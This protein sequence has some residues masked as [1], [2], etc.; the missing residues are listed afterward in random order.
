MRFSMILAVLLIIVPVPMRSDSVKAHNRIWWN[1]LDLDTK[2]SFVAGYGEGID[3]ADWLVEQAIRVGQLKVME[4]PDPVTPHLKF[5][6]ITYGQFAEGLD[7]F[8]ADYRNKQI[9]FNVAILYI[10]DQIQGV[11]QKDLDVRLE[12]MRQATTQ[13]DYDEH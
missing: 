10:R 5:Y 1:E 6:N 2:H 4:S 8:Y 3:R 13:A 12:H 9:N 11:P 7:A